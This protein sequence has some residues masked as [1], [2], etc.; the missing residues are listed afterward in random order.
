MQEKN[1]NA[2]AKRLEK[3]VVETLSLDTEEGAGSRWVLDPSDNLLVHPEGHFSE[4]PFQDFLGSEECL[5]RMEL[6]HG[7]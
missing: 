6:L 3:R 1:P 5:S 2:S 4:R 7:V